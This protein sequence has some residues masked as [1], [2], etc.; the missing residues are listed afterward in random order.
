LGAVAFNAICYFAL[1]H[2]W[3]NLLALVICAAVA[4]YMIFEEA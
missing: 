4:V 1:G 2:H 3:W